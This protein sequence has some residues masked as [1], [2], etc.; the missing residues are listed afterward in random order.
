VARRLYV[1]HGILIKD[2]ASKSMPEAE[3]YLRIAS[4]TTD[5]NRSLLDALCQMRLDQP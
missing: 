5:E 3:R 1:E 4:R 2:C